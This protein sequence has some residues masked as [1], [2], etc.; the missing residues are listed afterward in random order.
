MGCNWFDG[1]V[2]GKGG[3]GKI[4]RGG[5]QGSSSGRYKVR[6]RRIV[7]EGQRGIFGWRL[8]EN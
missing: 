3:M 8:E 4:E 1:N 2:G 7:G 5:Y 6:V